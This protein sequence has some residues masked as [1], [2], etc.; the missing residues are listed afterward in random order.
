MTDIN[1]NKFLKEA[2]TSDFQLNCG[3]PLGYVTGFPIISAVGK[4]L[5]LKVPFLK[6]KVTGE[7]DKTLVY[8]VKYVITY[9]LPDM[10]PVCFEDLSY[11]KAFSKID[12]SQPI[13][14]F[15]HDAIK[16][17]NKAAYKEKKEE[18]IGMYDK[19]ASALINNTP[20]TREDEAEFRNLLSIMLEPSVKPIYKSLDGKFYDKFLA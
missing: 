2:K 18:L 16:N 4:K 12:F 15:R 11:N 13:G 19:L 8:P 9:S 17:L 20:Y 6:Y 1:I 3:M 14:F 10:K 5:C 7:V